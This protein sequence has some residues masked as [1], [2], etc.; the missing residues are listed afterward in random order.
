MRRLATSALGFAVVLAALPGRA[1]PQSAPLA[2]AL[3][4]EGQ[5]LILAHQVHEACEKFAASLRI[6]PAL[7]TLLNLADCHEREG[8]TASAWTEFALVA[9]RA[10][11][12]NEAERASYATS[13]HDA[14][15]GKL[16][17]VVLDVTRSPRLEA[18]SVDGAPLVREAWNVP[19]PLDPGD[20]AFAFSAKRKHTETLV[21]HVPEGPSRTPVVAPDLVDEQVATPPTSNTTRLLGFVIGGVG[22]VGVGIGTFY[23][24]RTFSLKSDASKDCNGAVCGASGYASGTDAQTSATISTVAFGVGLAALA[25]GTWF[26][27]R[28]GGSGP[29]V[30]AGLGSISVR[31]AF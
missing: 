31:G 29:Q 14:L 30:S 22:V 4:E 16:A 12:R 3:F 9:S 10:T 27:L 15:E 28:S 13:H 24:I 26:V 2:Q 11:Q 25:V 18:I 21:V 1:D 19:V 23:G 17:R 6:D 8:K 20:H 7:G 5:R